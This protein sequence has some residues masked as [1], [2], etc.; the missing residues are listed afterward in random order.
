MKKLW[1]LIACCVALPAVA[2]FKSGNMLLRQIDGDFGEQMNAIGYVSGV[3]DALQGAVVC[4]P[5]TVTA[6]QLVDMTRLYLERTPA[7][8]HLAADLLISEVLR[9][10]WPCGRRGGGA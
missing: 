10:A 8:R 6:G 9:A 3:A 2:Q 1:V 5:H 4:A 7:R